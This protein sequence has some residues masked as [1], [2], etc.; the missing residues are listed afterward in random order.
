MTIANTLNI[1]TLNVNG[2]TKKLKDS[3]FVNTVNRYDM[4]GVVETWSSTQSNLNVRGYTL[5]S[6]NAIKRGKRGS[7]YGGVALYFKHKYKPGVH[8]VASSS[9]YCLWVRLDGDFFGL[10][11]DLY[12]GVIYLR[13]SNAK[14]RDVYFDELER[15][16]TKY[17]A[18]GDIMITGDFNARTQTEMDYIYQMMSLRLTTSHCP[19]HM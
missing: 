16:V 18:Q 19:P 2:L 11:K 14:T 3:T 15:D 4:F 17:E 7:K 13:P 8:L 1:A 9:K 10:D 6:K 12:L 5:Y